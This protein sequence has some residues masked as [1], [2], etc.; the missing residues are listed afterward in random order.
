M[1]FFILGSHS[2]LSKAEISALFSKNCLPFSS[3]EVL[4]TEESPTNLTELQEKLGG[5]IKIGGIVGEF[6][7][8]DMHEAAD[9][10]AALASGAVGK[11]KISF[12]ISIYDGGNQE[13]TKELRKLSEKL[14]LEIKK[15]LK[16]YGRPVRLVTSKEKTLS[17]VVVTKNQLLAS[18]GEFVIIPTNDSIFIGQTETVQDYES[19]SER[20][21]GRPRRNAKS[22]MLPPK[23]A[24]I[25]INLSGA[26]PSE[27]VLLDPFCGSGTV[28]ME[29]ALLSYKQIIGS[30]ISERAIA[31]T[32]KN[33]KWLIRTNDLPDPDISLYTSPAEKLEEHLA[34]S[35]DVVVTETYLGPPRSGNET[36]GQLEILLKELLHMYIP[37]FQ[38]INRILKPGG[39]AVV[40]FPAYVQGKRTMHLP[41]ETQLKTIGFEITDRFLYKRVGQ[42]V[43][44]DIL[45]LKSSRK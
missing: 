10:I 31:D 20:D 28:L 12:G 3:E 34:Q 22:G 37:S 17:A 9:L 30:D 13:M 38:T 45:L 14:G 1:T 5:T 29:A 8:W 24:R 40:A 18:G 42:H 4:F 16:E 11:D 44:R 32:E 15:R 23:L 27:S 2:D 6:A 25:M 21:Y 41:I 39:V 35:V 26:T 7:H 33:L 36:P 43:A 19:W